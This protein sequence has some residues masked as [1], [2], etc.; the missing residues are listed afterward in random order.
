MV[1]EASDECSEGKHPRGTAALGSN[2]VLVLGPRVLSLP[3][4]PSLGTLWVPPGGASWHLE[5]LQGFC[6]LCPG[7]SATSPW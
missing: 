6:R 3:G 5:G 7:F 2:P 1:W 4:S